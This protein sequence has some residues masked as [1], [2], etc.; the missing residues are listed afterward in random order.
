MPA[1]DAQFR[2]EAVE[3]GAGHL[4]RRA[5]DADPA[6]G[7]AGTVED[8]HADAMDAEDDLL[9]VDRIAAL[10]DA[11]DLPPEFRGI[12]DRVRRQPGQPEVEDT[13]LLAGADIGEHS[14]AR[15]AAM[16]RAARADAGIELHSL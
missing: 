2:D 5:R 8:G 13:L 10:P 14:L 3:G 6:D 16:E 11:L 4:R 12:G 7:A 9:V 15:A 1:R